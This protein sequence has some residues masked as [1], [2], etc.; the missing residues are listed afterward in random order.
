MR[1][2]G[3]VKLTFLGIEELKEPAAQKP[4]NIKE[5]QRGRKNNHFFLVYETKSP[6]NITQ[7]GDI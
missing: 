5:I 1:M 4:S 6:K 3:K 7:K 2:T